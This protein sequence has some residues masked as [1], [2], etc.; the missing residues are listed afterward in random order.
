MEY[1]TKLGQELGDIILKK[2][3]NRDSPDFGF[4]LQK[5]DKNNYLEAPP[6][7]DIG[8]YINRARTRSV[9]EEINKAAV[10]KASAVVGYQVSSVP[11]RVGT[12]EEMGAASG[13]YIRDG[14]GLEEILLRDNFGYFRQG[15]LR[16]AVHEYGH[17]IY[18]GDFRQRVG[19]N[20]RSN[21]YIYASNLDEGFAYWFADVA[22]EQK[23]RESNFSDVYLDPTGIAEVYKT[24]HSISQVHGV[25]FVLDHFPA[26]A[27]ICIAEMRQQR[28]QQYL[29]SLE[30]GSARELAPL[31]Q[32]LEKN[33]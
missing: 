31:S 9:L 13:K 6:L 28:H 4:L 1:P 18:T 21:D 27:G 14:K 33:F 20:F 12:E 29:D 17:K 10:A 2:D 30:D 8:V 24:L 32:L 16:T 22:L 7:E 11:I 15:D 26:I 19:Y 3:V 23:P 25:K 5:L